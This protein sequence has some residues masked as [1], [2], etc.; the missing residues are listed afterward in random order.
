MSHSNTQSFWE[1]LELLGEV[2]AGRSR[3]LNGS[4]DASCLPLSHRPV[5]FSTSCLPRSDEQ[6]WLYTT[7]SMRLC[8]STQT[9]QPWIEPLKPQVKINSPPSKLSCPYLVRGV[10]KAMTRGGMWLWRE[11][12]R[13]EHLLTVAVGCLDDFADP[14]KM[15]PWGTGSEGPR[16]GTYTGQSSVTEG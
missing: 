11:A 5:S 8:L 16:W 15:S 4:S 2:L 13:T 14:Q 3:P 6:P 9:E 7:T 1:V 10:R 12:L